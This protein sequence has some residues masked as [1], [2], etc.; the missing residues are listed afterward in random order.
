MLVVCLTSLEYFN[1]VF[2]TEV[3]Q[4]CIVIDGILQF[5]LHLIS[6]HVFGEKVFYILVI[7]EDL[8]ERGV[9]NVVVTIECTFISVLSYEI[10]ISHLRF[11]KSN[12]VLEI[13][14]CRIFWWIVLKYV[15]Y[16]LV[17]EEFIILVKILITEFSSL[18]CIVCVSWKTKLVIIPCLHHVRLIC[19]VRNSIV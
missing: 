13:H 12:L 16:W 10:S 19:Q 2:L 15:V 6:S 18:L 17:V 8:S 4:L 11:L 7:I 9:D 1:V 14:G 3:C 5:F